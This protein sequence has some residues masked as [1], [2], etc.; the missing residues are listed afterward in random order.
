[1]GVT[2]H[3]GNWRCVMAKNKLP[4]D[5]AGGVLVIQKR[6]ISSPAYHGLS[7]QAKALI[8]LL[9]QH[10]RHD[11]PVDYGLR[12]A[13]R[14]IPCSRKLATRAFNQLQDAGFIECVGMS[15]FNSRDG[16]KAREWR[17]TWLPYNGHTPTNEWEAKINQP[18][19]KRPLWQNTTVENDRSTSNPNL[20]V[21]ENDRRSTGNQ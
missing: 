11:K 16:S 14:L 15:Q 6:L 3:S 21:V 2:Y 9:Q 8:P 13:T 18:V 5:K 17:L 10:W 19:D 1:M 4:F 7:A 20:R 12:E